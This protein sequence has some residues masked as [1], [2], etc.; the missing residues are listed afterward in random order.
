VDALVIGIDGRSLGVPP[1]ERYNRP[2]MLPAG[3]PGNLS[4]A[5]RVNLLIRSNTPVNSFAKVEFRHNAGDRLL[6]TGRIPIV[7]S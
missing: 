7:I 6:L 1:F 2:F 4:T 3:T 5:Q